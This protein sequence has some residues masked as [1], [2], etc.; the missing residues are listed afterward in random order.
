MKTFLCTVLLVVGLASVSFGQQKV[1]TITA[2]ASAI[3]GT[4]WVSI[5]QQP[6]QRFN[7]PGTNKADEAYR[8]ITDK[9]QEYLDKGWRIIGQSSAGAGNLSISY[10]LVKDE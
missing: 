3:S 5:S 4:L 2:S 10:T 9:I 7:L 8:L 6:T 1:M